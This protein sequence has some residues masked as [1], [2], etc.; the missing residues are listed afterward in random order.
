MLTAY[1]KGRERA[2][3]A[4]QK[5]KVVVAKRKE[6]APEHELAQKLREKKQYRRRNLCRALVA[7]VILIV[8]A[9]VWLGGAR[10]VAE[11]TKTMDVVSYE[12]VSARVA[13]VFG[14]IFVLSAPIPGYSGALYTA[15]RVFGTWWGALLSYGAATLG[16]TLCFLI[17]RIALGWI[18]VR[19]ARKQD[20]T[21]PAIVALVRAVKKW[22]LSSLI[23]VRI[24]PLPYGLCN[25]IVGLSRCSMWH[26]IVAL[27]ITN[28]KVV[29]YTYAGASALETDALVFSVS[30]GEAI[31][32]GLALV[33]CVPAIVI[34]GMCTHNEMK[35][36]RY[37]E[38]E[39]FQLE[40]AEQ[41][42][43]GQS[44]PSAELAA[45]MEVAA[46]EAVEDARDLSRSNSDG[47]DSTEATTPGATPGRTAVV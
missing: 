32:V 8:V 24:M 38:V 11:L 41:V 39:R 15:G 12:P 10:G 34:L 26:Y 14:I 16:G 43:A 6:L 21:H 25:F 45:A 29:V 33:V 42:G 44:G 22:G 9:A 7:L 2:R 28:V 36:M 4:H 27:A 37:E 35:L 40:L 3:V 18:S 1:A 31:W 23:V 46:M 17:T 19:L 13:A 47:G 30:L 20:I 5:N